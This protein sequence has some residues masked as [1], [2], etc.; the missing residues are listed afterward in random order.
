MNGTR[1]RRRLL[2]ACLAAAVLSAAVGVRVL[3]R[4]LCS[5]SVAE[6]RIVFPAMGTRAGC[7]FYTASGTSAADAVAAVRREFDRVTAACN[8]HD[9]ESELSRLNREA[10]QGFFRCSPLLWRVLVE[11]RRAHAASSGAFD[12]TVKPLMD[13][14]GFYRKRRKLPNSEELAAALTR[15]GFDKLWE[16]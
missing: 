2:I 13:L 5:P 14:W 10:G 15:V 9:P 4:R 6:T 11:A 3:Y 12:V 7:T 8:L 1:T 16:R